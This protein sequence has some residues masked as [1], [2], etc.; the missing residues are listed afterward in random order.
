MPYVRKFTVGERCKI[1]VTMKAKLQGAYVQVGKTECFTDLL[2]W[3]NA[4]STVPAYHKYFEAL[5]MA[6]L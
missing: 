5:V 3:K 6:K 4:G 2:I 1:L